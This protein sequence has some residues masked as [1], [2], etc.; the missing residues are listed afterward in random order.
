MKRLLIPCILNLLLIG[1]AACDNNEQKED[2]LL[3]EIMAI[4]D[5]A[6]PINGKLYTLSG[7]LNVAADSIADSTRAAARRQAAKQALE[8]HDAMMIWMSEFK[9]PEELDGDR[10]DKKMIEYLKGEKKKIS[11]IKAQME[12]AFEQTQSFQ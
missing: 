7:K 9:L 8:A 4:H 12:E 10:N 6:M 3:D 11:D 5:E 1:A 2:T